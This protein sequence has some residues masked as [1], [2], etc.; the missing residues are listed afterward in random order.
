MLST[1]V[2]NCK[3]VPLLLKKAFSKLAL[4]LTI[5]LF[6]VAA[7]FSVTTPTALASEIET[8]HGLT[9]T[10]QVVTI[11]VT[12]TGCTQKEDFTVE[13][14]K[15]LP[16]SVTFSRVNPDYC[17]GAARPYPIKFSFQEIGLQEIG[18]KE[19]KVANTVDPIPEF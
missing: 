13:L 4:S 9:V 5:L 14:D 17:K 19:F 2:N 3:Q 15:S 7:V 6:G 11:F 10:E 12:S 18:T 8:L 1:T 16:P